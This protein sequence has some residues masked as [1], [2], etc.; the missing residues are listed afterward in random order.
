MA[1]CG[2]PADERQDYWIVQVPACTKPVSRFSTSSVRWN[3]LFAPTIADFSVTGILTKRFPEVS[4]TVVKAVFTE[5]AL[6]SNTFDAVPGVTGP[7][8]NPTS[9]EYIHSSLPA[10]S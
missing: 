9:L 10:R 4:C 7:R 2:L 1:T 3:V 8:K 6:L 5:Q